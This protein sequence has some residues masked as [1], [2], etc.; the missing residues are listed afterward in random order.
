M[1]FLDHLNPYTSDFNQKLRRVKHVTSLL[2]SN[3]MVLQNTA[4]RLF[5]TNLAKKEREK[6]VKKN[7]QKST[8]D[9]VC[10]RVLI[11][12]SIKI[13]RRKE[14]ERAETLTKKKET[15]EVKKLIVAFKKEKKE[16]A[17]SFERE[18]YCK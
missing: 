6:K 11:E 9:T 13:I 10:G 12:E 8:Y 2:V 4:Q 18:G 3:R 15:I 14:E 7:G 1:N 17:R 16:I 5:K